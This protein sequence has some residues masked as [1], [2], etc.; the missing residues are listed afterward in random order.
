[1]SSLSASAAT[2]STTIAES[3]VAS[4]ATHITLPGD[5]DP[6]TQT[7]V[8]SDMGDQLS[9]DVSL[10]ASSS[11]STAM[12]E[13]SS[14]QCNTP[15][16]PTAA[17]ISTAPPPLHPASAMADG[18][19]VH[20][21]RVY[22]RAAEDSDLRASIATNVKHVFHALTGFDVDE[23][24]DL[25]FV[26]ETWFSAEVV[27]HALCLVNRLSFRFPH[28]CDHAIESDTDSTSVAD[29]PIRGC[30]VGLTAGLPHVCSSTSSDYSHHDNTDNLSEAS[31][32]FVGRSLARSRSGSTSSLGDVFTRSTSPRCMIAL[33]LLSSKFHGDIVYN[34][35]SLSN[36][37][38]KF[39][40]EQIK[41]KANAPTSLAT[42]PSRKPLL[43]LQP[44]T[45]GQCEKRL[46]RDLGCSV[47]V[48]K[49]EFKCCEDLVMS[50]L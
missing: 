23:I 1:M 50:G 47:F 6:N 19:G 27:I 25:L 29:S 24:I 13:C 9:L 49:D 8:S 33:L 21:P 15:V 30:G 5:L 46:F 14:T 34:T 39:R 31:L 36:A 3:E 40:E 42:G 45:L 38:N 35:S 16:H 7:A 10:D 12:P 2:F 20:V 22:Q 4:C 17:P 37:V 18:W 48:H 43:R 32:D 11:G 28:W 44:A 41:A 26:K